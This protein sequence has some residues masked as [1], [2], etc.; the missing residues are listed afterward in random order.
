M[1]E[2]VIEGL[3]ENQIKD[4]RTAPKV[5]K[6]LSAALVFLAFFSTSV[7]LAIIGIVKM[8]QADLWNYEPAKSPG[9]GY[10][11][12]TAYGWV[13]DSGAAVNGH[14]FDHFL[15]SW[16]R[17]DPLEYID[18][19]SSLGNTS[20][21]AIIGSLIIGTFVPMIYLGLILR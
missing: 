4:R 1:T 3:D 17:G 19:R 13:K 2:N 6:D 21:I 20:F 8:A 16:V 14:Y 9:A 7:V 15:E 10:H 18:P 12:D 5:F 11:Y